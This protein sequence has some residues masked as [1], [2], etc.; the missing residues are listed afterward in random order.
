MKRALSLL[1]ALMLCLSLC[2][3]RKSNKVLNCEKQIEN[4]GTITLD[5]YP[6]IEAARIFYDSLSEKEQSQI[7]NYDKLT[8]AESTYETLL[9]ELNSQVD[10]LLKA[11]PSKETLNALRQLHNCDTVNKA[12][13][14]VSYEILEQYLIS[15]NKELTVRSLTLEVYDDEYII[16]SEKSDSPHAGTNSSAEYKNSEVEIWFKKTGEKANCFG[17]DW[18]FYNGSVFHV[19]WTTH[20]SSADTIEEISELGTTVD[21]GDGTYS[22]P[23]TFSEEELND[24]FANKTDADEFLQVINDALKMIKMPF[25]AW[26]LAGFND[27]DMVAASLNVSESDNKD[28]ESFYPNT[29]F[30]MFDSYA[31]VVPE[32]TEEELW[33]VYTYRDDIINTDEY[34]MYT[35]FSGELQL[36]WKA[37]ESE[38]L[39]KFEETKGSPSCFVWLHRHYRSHKGGQYIPSR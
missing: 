39:S 29:T 1:I 33:T 24:I 38:V 14:A 13:S 7:G 8:E 4:L 27:P 16:A 3:C 34:L 22:W 37:Y 25:S 10:T 6:V 36:A 9:N 18:F 5:S 11:E 35:S 12:I 26:E 31:N 21:G 28:A 32:I 2:A 19:S 20:L 15:E 23:Y 30:P 17:T